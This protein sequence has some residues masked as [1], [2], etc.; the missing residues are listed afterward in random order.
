MN[1]FGLCWST[2]GEI[3]TLSRIA[4]PSAL[5]PF[6]PLPRG[7]SVAPGSPAN[8]PA[9]VSSA[10]SVPPRARR[11]SGLPR[12]APEFHSPSARTAGPPLGSPRRSLAA[13]SCRARECSGTCGLLGPF[14]DRRPALVRRAQTSRCLA[15]DSPRQRRLR[16]S[17]AFV[18]YP[19]P[20]RA[21]GQNL[22]A[23]EVPFP[24]L[25]RCARAGG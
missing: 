4:V 1:P 21:R 12:S 9:R 25:K 13:R 6:V 5:S 19:A 24:A 7:S 16:P 10:R 18:R 20:S 8:R 11:S 23:P 17:Y 3:P 22:R 2:S 15:A 14:R